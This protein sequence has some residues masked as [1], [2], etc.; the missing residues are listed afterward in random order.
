MALIDSIWAT[1]GEAD[2]PEV[3]LS[4]AAA[5]EMER[6]AAELRANPDSGLS[7]DEVKQWLKDKRWK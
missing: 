4:Q 6:R 2:E 7:H 5:T 3:E 1:I